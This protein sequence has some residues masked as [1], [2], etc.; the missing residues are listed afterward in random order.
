MFSKTIPKHYKI[1]K[2]M[3]LK[4]WQVRF[5]TDESWYEQYIW[6]KM[7]PASCSDWWLKVNTALCSV[8]TVQV[9]CIWYGGP[10]ILCLLQSILNKRSRYQN[11][12]SL[13]KYSIQLWEVVIICKYGIGLLWPPHDLTLG[14]Q[15][16]GLS[17]TLIV[18]VVYLILTMYHR[19]IWE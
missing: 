6:A 18:L 7:L 3:I 11:F 8:W 17:P 1:I 4:W 16:K 13:S 9:H 5:V 19:C 14:S 12:P 15:W 10:G 2:I